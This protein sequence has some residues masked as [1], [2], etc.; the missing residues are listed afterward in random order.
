[1]LDEKCDI[2]ILI[3]IYYF[4]KVEKKIYNSVSMLKRN[5]TVK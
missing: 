1:M 3:K 2:R 4:K 5:K